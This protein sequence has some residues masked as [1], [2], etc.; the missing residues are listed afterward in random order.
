MVLGHVGTN[1]KVQS[2]S[3]RSV[4][5]DRKA[6]TKSTYSLHMGQMIQRLC[7]RS[8]KYVW[9]ASWLIQTLNEKSEAT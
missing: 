1:A 4:L 5:S 3:Q 8:M 6:I 9:D 2:L 7:D